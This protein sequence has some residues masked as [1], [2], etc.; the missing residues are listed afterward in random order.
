MC[1]VF[2][3]ASAVTEGTFMFSS[4]LLVALS[5]VPATK[6]AEATFYVATN[7]EDGWSGKLSER[8]AE[9]G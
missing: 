3:K 1:Q 6:Q 8:N 4:L 2:V 7:S 9:K 5:A